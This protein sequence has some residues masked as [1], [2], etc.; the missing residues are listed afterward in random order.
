MTT[1]SNI[2]KAVRIFRE[3]GLRALFAKI[4]WRLE[5]RRQAA[6]FREWITLHAIDHEERTAIT[7]EID[8]F[9]RRPLISVIVPVYNID[10]EWLRRCIGSVQRQLYTNWEL[11]LADDCSPNPRVREVLAELA[12]ADPRIKTVFRESNGH[13]SAASNSALELATGEFCVLL[14]HDDELSEDALFRVAKEILD[15]PET[16]FIY[17]DEDLIDEN[18]RRFEPKFKPDFSLD[19]LY[20]LNLITH[21]SAYRTDVLRAIGGFRIGLE[22]SQ[23]YDLALRVFEVIGENRIRHIPRILYHWRAIRGSAAFGPGEKPYAYE[24]AREAIRLHLDR[25]KRSARV[26]EARWL[27]NRV[28]YEL[29]P[30]FEE[31][32][33]LVFGRSIGSQTDLPDVEMIKCE[34]TADDLNRASRSANGDVLC[35]LNAALRPFGD[36]WLSELVSFLT[37]NEIGAVGPKIVGPDGMTFG[38]GIVFGGP[39]LLRPAHRRMPRDAAGN[40]CRNQL[41]SNFSAVAIDCL[42]IRRELFAE[43][44]G[45]DAATFGTSLFDAD[46]CLRLR[47]KG[48]RIVQTPYAELHGEPFARPY[49]E[50]EFSAFRKKW[51]SVVDRDPFYNPN[52]SLT[53][54]PFSLGVE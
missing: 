42:A 20:S 43:L 29:S 33:L 17:S 36:D 23:D 37:Q 49:L 50:T 32:S 24:R 18:G 25:T 12:S 14:D 34:P 54:R 2:G 21:L 28:R 45:F 30:R 39:E 27:M 11:C 52:L 35:F 19:L 1:E 13:I 16:D 47:S 6:R 22:G 38:G 5:E 8:R 48:Y 51:R 15:H 31:V 53:G 44:G 4:A 3:E 26:T 41:I 9:S 10:E 40:M 7:G 46:L